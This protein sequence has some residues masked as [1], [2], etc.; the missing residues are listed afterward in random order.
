MSSTRT[1]PEVSSFPN[2]VETARV[3][4]A[5]YLGHLAALAAAGLAAAFGRLGA[6]LE[7]AYEAER[8]RSSQGTDPYGRLPIPRI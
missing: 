2:P 1:T 4:R 8:D 3:H 7:R 6:R 5:A